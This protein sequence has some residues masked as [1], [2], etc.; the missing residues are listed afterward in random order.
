M[1]LE[2]TQSAKLFTLADA[3][4]VLPSI[5]KVTRTHSEALQPWQAKLD[6]MLSNDP[7]RPVIERE[8]ERL[9]S[10]W[11]GKIKRVGARAAGLWVVEF[12]VGDGALSWRYPELQ[13]AHF[14]SEHDTI[15]C[16][17]SDYIEE[18]D[19]DWAL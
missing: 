19:P 2:I 16:R 18:T 13:I 5:I 7:R 15:R 9:V 6:R 8:Y 4:R 12:D 1:T 17:L 11:R 10:V 3:Q 14:R